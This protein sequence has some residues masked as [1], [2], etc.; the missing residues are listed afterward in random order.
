M[1]AKKYI[2][3]KRAE[4]EKIESATRAAAASA[5]VGTFTEEFRTEAEKLDRQSEYW[6]Y[7]SLAFA[8][9]TIGAAIVFFFWP[10][11]SSDAGMSETL[12]I[13][14][15]KA[16]VIVVLFSGAVWCGRIYRSF[17]HRAAVNRHRALSLKT[18]QAF[19]EASD[20]KYVKDAVLM[21]ATNTVFRSVPTGLVE[22]GD[23]QDPGVNFVEFGRPAAGTAAEGVAQN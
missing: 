15:S 16:A 21:A 14:A 11:V 12:R 1:M 3:G 7:S 10:S 23:S 5:G 13:M 9:V 4:I 8:A 18:F 17:V 19:V 2:T 20:D 22:E 6:L